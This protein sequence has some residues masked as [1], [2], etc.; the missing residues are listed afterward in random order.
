MPESVAS[1]RA[2]RDEWSELVAWDDV[3]SDALNKRSG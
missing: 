2:H 3:A 1:E